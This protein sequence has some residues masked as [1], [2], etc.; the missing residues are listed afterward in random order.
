MQA[1]IGEAEKNLG[2]EGANLSLKSS[3]QGFQT[4]AQNMKL[5][6]ILQNIESKSDN[7]TDSTSWPIYF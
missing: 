7:E 5:G 4:K 3:A 2:K 6:K 1:A